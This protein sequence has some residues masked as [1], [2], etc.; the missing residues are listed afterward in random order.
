MKNSAG[1]Q[2]TAK[3]ASA[4]LGSFD[5]LTFLIRFAGSIE[6]TAEPREDFCASLQDES[7]LVAI[8]EFTHFV[9]ATTTAYGLRTLAIQIDI[10]AL[11]IELLR[12]AG[13]EFRE[14]RYLS[15]PLLGPGSIDKL[16]TNKDLSM[17]LAAYIQLLSKWLY[18]EGG[19]EVPYKSLASAEPVIPMLVY[20]R[21]EFSL[22]GTHYTTPLFI[23]DMYHF[24][25]EKRA[26]VLGA[27]HLREGAAKAVEMV[28][29]FL[30]ETGTVR[31]NEKVN[32]A[33]LSA[34]N[35]YFVLISLSSIL[36]KVSLPKDKEVTLEELILMCDLALMLD[37][38]V[39]V[40]AEPIAFGSPEYGNAIKF[41]VPPANLFMSIISALLSSPDGIIRFDHVWTK[42]TVIS[43]QNSLLE[44]VVT[45]GAENMQ[46]L[47]ESVKKAAHRLFEHYRKGC[48]V[49]M[50]LLDVYQEIISNWLR[51]RLDVLG[52]GAVIEDLLVGKETFY[53]MAKEV[54]PAYISKGNIHSRGYTVSED[55]GIGVELNM[56][57]DMSELTDK[58]LFGDGVCPEHVSRPRICKAEPWAFCGS[59][60]QI[61]IQKD[62]ER[63]IRSMIFCHLLKAID[64][65]DVEWVL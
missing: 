8:H 57:R 64:A 47:T 13:G 41:D 21:K 1:L 25:R 45:E 9:Q 35:P 36:S 62:S 4:I 7:F 51:F 34:A 55:T 32:L 37:T 26:V 49:P 15:L 56:I 44:R 18:F 33:G 23:V 11:K 54:L 42:E 3:D 27:R 38:Y 46:Q 17:T 16:Q 31:A 65:E 59:M 10:L 22:L 24:N 43:F 5:P 40:W 53:Q 19:W 61:N 20:Q 2:L 52:G 14:G 30:T 29:A 50:H 58:M 63:C 48:P 28:Q 12:K 39:H 6:G 60:K